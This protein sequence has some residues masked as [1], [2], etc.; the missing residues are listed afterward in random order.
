MARRKQQPATADGSTTH[1]AS[2]QG[3][4]GVGFVRFWVSNCEMREV[5]KLEPPAGQPAP[6]AFPIEIAM[7]A[8]VKVSREGPAF[9]ILTLAAKGDPHY[10]PYEVTVEV[11]GEFVAAP[12]QQVDLA[13]FCKEVAPNILFPY[14]R[15]IVDR[16]TADGR[17]GPL[18]I[19]P[20]NVRAILSQSKWEQNPNNPSEHASVPQPPSSR[21]PSASQE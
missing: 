17:F 1:E 8:G 19:N 14:A 15:Q 7:A 18:R 11:V 16:L 3:Q 2:M 4:P 9:S 6:K 10:R 5:Q 12:G 21:S 13:S 20:L